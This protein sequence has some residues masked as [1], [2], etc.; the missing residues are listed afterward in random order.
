[1][2]A[3]I[4]LSM[5]QLGKKVV[6]V[7]SNLRRPTIF[8]TF[9][10]NREPGLSDILMGNISWK[11][12]INTSIDVLTGGINIDKLLQMPGIDNLKIITCG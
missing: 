3:N 6:L 9:G 7:A 2:V 1:M 10:L 5:A 12:A 4:A 11:S 8:K